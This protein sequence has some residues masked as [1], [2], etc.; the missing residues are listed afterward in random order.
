MLQAPS[1]KLRAWSLEPPCRPPARGLH[2]GATALEAAARRLNQA[3]ASSGHWRLVRICTERAWEAGER[4][5]AA[6][7]LALR[8]V[9]LATI[10]YLDALEA[11]REAKDAW[12]REIARSFREEG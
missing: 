1:S 9:C 3:R 12:R 6:E 7:R 10:R 8:R 2:S 11:E 5:T 4:G